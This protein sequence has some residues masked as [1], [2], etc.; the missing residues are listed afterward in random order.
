MP[1]GPRNLSLND[2]TDYGLCFACGPRNQSGLRL[3]FERDGSTVRTEYTALEQHQGFPGYL[4]GGV[5]GALL[6]EVMSRVSVL[7]NRWTM[8]A[9]MEVRFRRP[10]FTGQ[11]V[12]AVGEKVGERRGFMEA[13]GRVLL[14]D[15]TLA[16]DAVGAFAPVSG[17]ALT[18]MSAG[19]PKLGREWMV[20]GD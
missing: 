3:T 19:Y 2:E 9:R 11:T 6:D 13:R 4:H 12:T 18:E 20:A 15:G 5:I 7:D 8:T 14:P 1:D 10:V 17:D 16:A